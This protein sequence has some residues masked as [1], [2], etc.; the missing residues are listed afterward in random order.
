MEFGERGSDEAFKKRMRIVRLAL[1]FGMKP[2]GQ[3]KGMRRQLD[4]F[5]EFAIGESP[6]KT[7][8]A[9]SNAAR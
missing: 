9:F 7:K 5:D 6:L 8:P 3:E 4:Q 1:K 2:A